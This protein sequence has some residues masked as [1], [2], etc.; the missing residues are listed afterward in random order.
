MDELTVVLEIAVCVLVAIIVAL[1]ADPHVATFFEAL[2]LGY[3]YD[4]AVNAMAGL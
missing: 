1:W 3:D 2:R 4:I